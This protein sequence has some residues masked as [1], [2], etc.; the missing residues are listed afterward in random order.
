[1]F[2]SKPTV[3]HHNYISFAFVQSAYIIMR[4]STRAFQFI[5]LNAVEAM[6]SPDIPDIGRILDV[7]RKL[8]GNG[9]SVPL[10]R[11]DIDTIRLFSNTHWAEIEN[12]ARQSVSPFPSH[13]SISSHVLIEE[14]FERYFGSHPSAVGRSYARENM[15]R[16]IAYVRDVMDTWTAYFNVTKLP[17]EWSQFIASLEIPPR[18]HSKSKAS[19]VSWAAAM[20][21]EQLRRKHF[22]T[23]LVERIAFALLIPHPTE[24]DDNLTPVIHA[25]PS[26]SMLP[27][28]FEYAEQYSPGTE[29]VSNHVSCCSFCTDF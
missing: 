13:E 28:W 11:D 29:E 18:P 8:Q 21:M 4:S 2:D 14:P 20:P 24:L 19:L 27:L 15:S 26:A 17:L 12:P 9:T 6:G 10:S 25:L 16:Y 5:C 7:Y 1:M 3:Y 23:R 22:A